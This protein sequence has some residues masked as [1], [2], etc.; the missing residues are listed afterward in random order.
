[1]LRI[2]VKNNASIH[3]TFI[4]V[5]ILSDTKN[6]RTKNDDTSTI[7]ESLY[8]VQ[9]KFCAIHSQVRLDCPHQIPR[10]S[11]AYSGDCSNMVCIFH[12]FTRL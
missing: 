7:L 6:K 3:T 10:S 11:V 9:T 4:S 5:P 12:L 2:K 1:M 8:S